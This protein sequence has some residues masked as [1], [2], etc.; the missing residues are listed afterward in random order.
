MLLLT[1]LGS[2]PHAFSVV[3]LRH[4]G[5][6][7]IGT[8]PSLCLP[9]TPTYSQNEHSTT[10]SCIFLGFIS[11]EEF[12]AMW[13]LF[14]SHYNVHIDDCQLNE[15]ANTMDLNKDGSIDFNEFLKAFYVVHKLK[16]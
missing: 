9:Y 5:G 8:A 1:F 13:N 2:L 7:L 6:C 3:M 16:G 10:F 11:M 12:Q 14:S 4:A 15:L